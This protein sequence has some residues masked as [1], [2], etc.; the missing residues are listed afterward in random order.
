MKTALSVLFVGAAAAAV[1]VGYVAP[2]ASGF[3]YR[4]DHNGPAS[5]IQLGAVPYHQ[6]HA[7]APPL[8]LAQPLALPLKLKAIEAYDLEPAPLPYV[9]AK[10]IVEEE[11]DDED[12]DDSDEAS[13]EYADGDLIGHDQGHAY[14]KGGG[15]DYEEKHH[16]AHGEKGIKGYKSSD[17]EA[18]GASGHYGKKHDEA[19]YSEGEGEIKAHHDEADAHGKH[20]QSGKQYKGG[21]NGHKKHF[22]KGEDVTGYHKVFHKDEFKKD[23]DFYDVADNSGNFKK[24]GY[25]KENHGSNAGAHK[26]GGHQKAAYDKGGYGK[27]GFHAKGHNDESD[28]SQ[29]AEEGNESHYKH[30]EDFGIKG[31]SAHEKEYIYEDDDEIEEDEE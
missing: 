8:P 16:A 20:H 26:K 5:L 23:H 24:H 22:S 31:G 28:H 25:E 6:P 29:S 18:K 15:S 14:E 21:K 10:P 27:A 4:N 1:S 30:G 13:E 11:Y 12:D 3:I 17:N 7:F 19:F 2:V 9:A